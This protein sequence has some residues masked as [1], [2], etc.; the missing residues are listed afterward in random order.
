[1]KTR[2]GTITRPWVLGVLFLGILL[3]T[4]LFLGALLGQSYVAAARGDALNAG[5]LYVDWE[6]A[7]AN[8]G[9]SW[10]DA[11]VDLQLALDA[12]SSG[13]EIWV[14]AGTYLPSVEHGGT[15][16]P[17]YQS[18]QML[19]GVG[20]YGGFDPSV[21]DIGREDRDW[22]ANETVLSG[23][24][25]EDGNIW[26]NSYH[27]FYHDASLGLDNTAV[28][29]GFT[30]SEGGNPW[31][32]NGMDPFGAGMVNVSASPTLANC[33]FE[34]NEAGDLGGAMFNQGASPILTNCTFRANRAEWTGGGAV[35]NQ[36]SS[37][38]FEACTFVDNWTYGIGG[39]AVNHNSSPVYNN[40][41]FL[42]NEAEEGGA[43][44]WN[45]GGSATVSNCAFI[46][47][48][49]SLADWGEGGGVANSSS[50]VVI[51]NS[52]FAFN[53]AAF[54][55]GGLNSWGGSVTVTNCTFYGNVADGEGGG[56]IYYYPSA[57]L[58]VTNSI[59]WGDMS[60]EIAGG[61]PTVTYSD[62]QGGFPGD[63]NI[64]E[65]PLFFDPD[66]KDYHLTEG[67]L[68]IDAG[69]NAAPELP[70]TDF[71]GDD[72]I[73]DGNG[74]GSSVADMGID[75]YV[76]PITGLEAAND[77]PT[78]LGSTTALTATI[79]AGTGVTY[80]WAF[81]DETFGTGK[82]VAHVYPAV[83][84]Y[85]AVVTATNSISEQW[86]ETMVRVEEAIA[87]LTAVNDG[88][89]T[90]G[91]TT[92]L[93]ATLTAGTAVSYTWAFGDGQFGQ[94]RIVTHVY[95]AADVYTAVVTATNPVSV[96]SAATLVTV[97]LPNQ[98]I[99]LPLIQYSH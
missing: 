44:M 39:G 12:A 98:P 50:A 43:G 2:S 32:W 69:T 90:L 68:A 5:T 21:G 49:A 59:L 37:P 19:N 35:Y 60:D 95:P 25:G 33:T 58:A 63:G 29:D 72:R 17:R 11:F 53:Y 71:E 82:E 94:G 47:N 9:S 8:D 23:D 73:L 13:D 38:V 65:D 24:I 89:T 45:Q 14:A 78:A 34:G 97:A 52:T 16:D 6:A 61:S 67:S 48:Q 20:I 10:E 30:I 3:A 83:G 51:T 28:L 57:P 40:C 22:V 86:A 15:G 99:Y 76:V 55:G 26:D 81:G 54:A 62:I 79:T 85:T 1:M 84:V 91:D 88:P 77:S 42:D 93:T 92:T 36:A 64:D 80:T 66:N 70:L 4:A 27:V 18:F 75:E 41:T 46:G 7:G 74:D 31:A 56:A 96:Q 87:G